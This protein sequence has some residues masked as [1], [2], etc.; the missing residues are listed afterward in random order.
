M[1]GTVTLYAVIHSDG[2]IR[3][4]RV[5]DGVDDQLD[6]YASEALGRCHFDPAIKNGAPVALEAV[7][8]IPFRARR[9]Y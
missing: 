8:M 1:Q 9:A 6:R 2:S 4:I 5:L 7:V 3:E